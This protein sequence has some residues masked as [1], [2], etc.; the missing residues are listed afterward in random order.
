MKLRSLPLVVVAFLLSI[1]GAV[2]ACFV[3]LL[4]DR[5]R[6]LLR[7]EALEADAAGRTADRRPSR[8]P[9]GSVLNDFDLPL[10]TGGRAALSRW[11]GRPLLL[12]VVQ[13]GC[14]ASRRLLTGLAGLVR[15]G[16]LGERALVIVSTG[17]PEVNQR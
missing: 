8:L 2:V 5:G 7:I 12:L 11:R 6:L 4:T 15:D 13:P 3:H 1:F 9:A 10:L 14:A 16:Q 17:A